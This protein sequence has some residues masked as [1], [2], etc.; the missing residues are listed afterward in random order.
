[1]TTPILKLVGACLGLML[2]LPA[3]PWEAQAAEGEVAV[4]ERAVEKSFAAWLEALWPDVEASGVS[5]ETFDANLKGLKLDWSLPHLVLP[6]PAG[7]CT[8]IA[9]NTRPKSSA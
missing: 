4:Y 1:M 9:L 7:A 2:A 5:R 8:M 3:L 6:N